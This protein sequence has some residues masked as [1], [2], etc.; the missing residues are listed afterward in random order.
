MDL[1][2]TVTSIFMVPTLGI[3]KEDLK[4]NNFLNAYIKD[5]RKEV[6]Y[7][8]C[9]YLLF[10]PTDMTKFR[11]FLDK[12]YERTVHIIDD[13]DYEDGFVVVV[14]RLDSTLKR[15]FELIRMGKYSL[16]S[17]NFQAKFPKIVKIM[18]GSLHRDEVSLQYRIFNK[19]ED[20]VQFWEDKLGVSFDE[21]QEVWHGFFEE[22][23][24][25]YLDKI[26]ELCLMKN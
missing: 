13:Y 16:T 6:Q 19:T 22:E 4:N 15:D 20:L 12:E 23:E 11:F 7:N 14:Y 18:K 8:D 5:G 17:S 3:D 24:T 1:K 26:K 21:D 10:Q 2:K 25:M 9:I